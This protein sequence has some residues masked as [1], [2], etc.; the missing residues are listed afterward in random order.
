MKQRKKIVFN[1]KLSKASSKKSAAIAVLVV[2]E[3]KG[4]LNELTQDNVRE[5]LNDLMLAGTVVHDPTEG[6]YLIVDPLYKIEGIDQDVDV[7]ELRRLFSHSNTGVAGR[8]GKPSDVKV[9][10]SKFKREYPEVT[11]YQILK[12]A[13]AYTSMV[14]AQKGD[15]CYKLP[16]FIDQ[17]LQDWIEDE[18][19]EKTKRSIFDK[20]K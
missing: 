19:Y 14:K 15:A 12:A 3:Q 13:K 5:A 10:L 11:K 17:E 16:N 18:I 4:S 7:T 20:R 1:E 8:M 9:A 2:I 6:K